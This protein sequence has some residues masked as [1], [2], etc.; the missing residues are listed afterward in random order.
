MSRQP[1]V[2]LLYDLV[3]TKEFTSERNWLHLTLNSTA[4]LLPTPVRF[5]LVQTRALSK[6][7]KWRSFLVPSTTETTAK[8]PLNFTLGVLKSSRV[9]LIIFKQSNKLVKS[10]M[11]YNHFIIKLWLRVILIRECFK[12]ERSGFLDKKK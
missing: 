3:K 9:F 5:G 11:K 8:S 2:G 10:V 6:R 7:N 12:K 4:A 1:P